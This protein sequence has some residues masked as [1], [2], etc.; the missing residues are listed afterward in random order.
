LKIYDL[1]GTH[2]SSESPWK[3]L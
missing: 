2:Q 3:C 1:T